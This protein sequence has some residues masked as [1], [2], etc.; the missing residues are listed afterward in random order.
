[1]ADDSQTSDS[2]DNPEKNNSGE[3]SVPTEEPTGPD[4]KGPELNLSSSGRTRDHANL[5][6][7]PVDKEES[8]EKVESSSTE[9]EPPNDNGEDSHDTY[10]DDHHHDDYHDPAHYEDD[11]HHDD[12]QDEDNDWW[13]E[14]EKD[15]AD[16]LSHAGEMS[17]LD[18]LEDL[19]WT[20]FKSVGAFIIGC[21][22]VGINLKFF[23]DLL[24]APIN[25]VSATGSSLVYTVS[26]DQ[27][28]QALD[29][30]TGKKK[31]EF[32][33]QFQP[34]IDSEGT[35]FAVTPDQ[36]IVALKGSTGKQKWEFKTDGAVRA[37]PALD[38]KGILYVG[39]ED[40]KVYAINANTGKK[41]WEF[42]A[43]A[44]VENSPLLSSDEDIEL[45]TRQ[46][47]GV[48]MVL[49]Q[50]VLFGGLAVSLPFI[51]MFTSGFVAPGLTKREKRMLLPGSIAAVFLFLA[52]AALAFFFIIPVSLKFSALLN[53]WMNIELLWDVNDYYSLVV[54]VTLAIGALFQFPLL[55]VI[56]G[57]LGIL[58][59]SKLRKGRKLVFVIILIVAALLT[60]G[61][62][63]VALV[64]LTIPLYGLFEGSIIMVSYVERGK[65]RRQARVEERRKKREIDRETAKQKA[66]SALTKDKHE[67]KSEPEKDRE[68]G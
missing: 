34:V 11:Y 22:L 64:L 1:M 16:Q 24:Q 38:T 58:P 48:L 63:I 42:E 13:E 10:H 41:K 28:L 47:L 31:W 21:I 51:I 53:D 33:V 37:P 54:M 59:S 55:L 5:P 18:H 25:Y 17:F 66:A 20:L 39:T 32:E 52:G 9:A 61:D 7:K 6:R 50:V 35:L 46:P 15:E 26:E 4:Q 65:A 67:D 68:G 40:R 45:R 29:R 62:V 8:G 60:P 44:A 3:E 23:A 14:D 43:S 30:S 12:P 2:P 27:K 57:Y 19:R 56:T 36:R 49:M